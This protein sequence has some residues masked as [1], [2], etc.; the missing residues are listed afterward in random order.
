[1]TH[2]ELAIMPVVAAVNA[3]AIGAV[4]R[5]IAERRAGRATGTDEKRWQASLGPCLG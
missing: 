3:Y 5:E 4:R 1:V 2:L